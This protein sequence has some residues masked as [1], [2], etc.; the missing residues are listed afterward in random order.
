MEV[1]EMR[2]VGVSLIL[3][4]FLIFYFL[5]RGVG[6]EGIEGFGVVPFFFDNL[7]CGGEDLNPRY[8]C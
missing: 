6:G 7:I 5:R 2:D 1:E 3:Y 8:V 4:E